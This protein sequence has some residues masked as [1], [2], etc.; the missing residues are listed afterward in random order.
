MNIKHGQVFRHK[1]NIYVAPWLFCSH[2]LSPF[3][4]F[5][6]LE[7]KTQLRGQR[8]GNYVY[9]KGHAKLTDGSV[10]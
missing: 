7:I 6:V 5:L 2:Y 9:K 1:K 4:Y 8:M 10:I 3:D